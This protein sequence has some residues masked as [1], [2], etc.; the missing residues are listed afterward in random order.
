MAASPRRSIEPTEFEFLC[1]IARPEPLLDRVREEL[2]SGL[3]FE[4]VLRL[5]ALH[6]VRPRL[7][8]ALAQVSW[9]RVPAE[10]RS[11]L[12]KFQ[13]NHLL[14]SLAYA[15]EL[16]GIARDFETAGIPFVAIKGLVLATLAYGDVAARE[17]NDMD[18]VV[19]QACMA[20]AEQVLADRGYRNSQGDQAFRQAFLAHQR[21]YAFKR[22]DADFAVDLHWALSGLYLPFPLAPEEIWRWPVPV[23]IAG[24]SIPTLGGADLALLLAGHGTKE[25]W[26]CLEW[27]SDFAWLVDRNRDLDWLDIYS[28]AIEHGCGRSVML[29]AALA[30]RLLGMPI[31]RDLVG[32]MGQYRDIHA[33]I[34]SLVE[35]V[36]GDGSEQGAHFVD[37]ELCDRSSDWLRAALSLVFTPTAG[38]YWAMPLPPRL[39]GLY[40]ATRPFRLAAKGPSVPFRTR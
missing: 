9:E 1:L 20:R 17:Y 2:R 31:P 35:Q 34:D 40:H 7:I 26:R 36:G 11:A 12:E 30:E 39:W 23:A 5:A 38:D 29:G 28:R 14:R 21:Q 8:R 13:R 33:R 32:I 3:V 16:C 37:L 22:V 18:I 24:R 27:V 4:K 15:E 10:V 19:P 25:G 6:G